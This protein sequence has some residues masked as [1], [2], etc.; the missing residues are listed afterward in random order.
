M[1]HIF[2]AVKQINIFF[3]S[4]NFKP[5]WKKYIRNLKKTLLY[6]NLKYLRFFLD[7]Y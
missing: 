1:T 4:I 2:K 5:F 6:N 7:L 3:Y